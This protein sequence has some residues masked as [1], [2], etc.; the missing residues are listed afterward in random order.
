ME[1]RKVTVKIGGT[2]YT[3]YSD[4]PDDYIRELEIRVN[5][6]M[7][8]TAA[9]SGFSALTG[10]V[11]AALLQTDELMRLE[12]KMIARAA[13]QPTKEKDASPAPGRRKSLPKPAG[14]DENQLS[15]WDLL[16]KAEEPQRT[17]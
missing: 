9:F 7:K 2:P 1:K 15:I 5:A 12:R 6:A 11:L 17:E 13:A 8:Q 10:A 3:F 14:K 4:D 16:G